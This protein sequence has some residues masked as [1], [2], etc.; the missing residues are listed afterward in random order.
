MR[1]AEVSREVIKEFGFNW[2][3][4]FNTGNFTFGFASGRDLISD[5][6]GTI[7]R[8]PAN[9]GGADPGIGFGAFNSGSASVSSAFD[10][11][12]EEGL[13]TVLAEPNLTALSGETASFLAGG[14]FPHSG[15]QRRQ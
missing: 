4:L 8:S 3:A 13:V 11:L 9:A 7:F 10:A 14:E 1:V 5:A 12:A 6:G 15:R 2:E